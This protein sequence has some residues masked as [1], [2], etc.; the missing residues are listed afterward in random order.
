MTRL[1]LTLLG[2]M[3]LCCFN[4]VAAAQVEDMIP[5]ARDFDSAENFAFEMRVGPYVPNFKDGLQNGAFDSSFRGDSGLMWELELD[6]IAYKIP[7]VLDVGVGTLIGWA[8]YSGKLIAT[9]G[10]G[11]VNE[12]T[13]AKIVPM[14]V[15]GVARLDILARKFDVPLLL[16]AKLGYQWTYFSTTPDFESTWSHGLRW[17]L[18]AGLDLDIFEPGQARMLDE[19]WG[20][21]HSF[22]LFEY[23]QHSVMGSSLEIGASAWSL[24]LGFMF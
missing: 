13:S 2:V 8:G 18:Q 7:N 6:T 15:M 3:G 23:Y 10:S 11:R 16:A 24:G 14:A 17:A 1:L 4:S 12:A 9:N 5:T 19:E 22:I 21:N 20:I